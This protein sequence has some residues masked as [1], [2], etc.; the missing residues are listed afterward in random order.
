MNQIPATVERFR[1]ALGRRDRASVNEA[2]AALIS[3]HAPLGMQWQSVA[4]ALKWNGEI[5]LALA[6]INEMDASLNGHPAA[7]FARANILYGSGRLEEALEQ[8]DLLVASGDGPRTDVERVG[9]L[10]FRGSIMLLLGRVDEAR[11]LLTEAIA[12]DPRSGQAWISFAELADFRG[13]D[14]GHVPTLEGAFRDGATIA[15]EASKL[16]HAVGRMRHQ[17][18][19]HAGAF[20]A[21][22]E[23]ARLYRADARQELVQPLD[24]LVG[25]VSSW[26]PQFIDE[27]ASRITVPH[28]RV[29][30]VSGLPRSGTTLVEQILVSHPRVETGEEVGFFRLLAQDIGAVDARSF[31]AW[32]DRG[33]DPNQLVELYNHLATERFGPDVAFVDK[34]IE[35]GNYMGLLLALFPKAPVFWLRRDPIDNGWSAFRTYFAR[36][37]GWSWD[38]ADIGTRLAQEDEMIA[39]W[40]RTAADRITFVDYEGLVRDPE[41]NIRR[42]AEAAGLDPVEQMFSPHETRRTVATA[43]VSQV[44][45]PINL[46]GLGVAEPYRQWL[47]PM[48]AAYER[49][50]AVK[51]GSA[52]AG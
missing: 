2:A 34:T 5:G 52:S 11:D 41:P 45:E 33:N 46:K 15:A 1:E 51:A 4:A 7:R 14:A 43:S 13:R 25:Q 19:D 32:L 20:A 10:N 38:L 26:S 40:S 16:A 48:T 27:I 29:L 12:I 24:Q 23:S 39:Y 6:A 31:R 30:F 18:R 50:R 8:L 22:S 47:G 49:A 36:G 17:L 35:A 28:D 21:F 9:H 3:M 42:I 37:A 44:R